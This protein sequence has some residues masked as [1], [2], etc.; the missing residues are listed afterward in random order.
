[1]IDPVTGVMLG[2][3][4]IGAL[5]KK[6]I[7]EATEPVVEGGVQKKQKEL[8]RSQIEQMEA[9]ELGLTEAQ[10]QQAIQDQMTA[11]GV[12]GAAQQAQLARQALGSE[13]YKQAG[14]A[15]AQQ[16]VARQRQQQ[17]AE[18]SRAART[19]SDALRER[20]LAQ[21]NADIAARAARK[22]ETMNYWRDL[23]L[24]ALGAGELTIGAYRGASV[25]AS[26]Q[27]PKTE[28]AFEKAS[29]NG[30]DDPVDGVPA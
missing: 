27:T 21:I 20:R 4:A 15:D 19:E 17:A 23:G 13:E 26:D 10:R 7:D 22:R 18:A 28:E 1:M 25:G 24:E 11:A 5:N 8:L 16:Q 2:S 9:G 14:L 6:K 29:D 12:Q 30:M 3:A